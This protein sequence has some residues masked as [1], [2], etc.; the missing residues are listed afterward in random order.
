MSFSCCVVEGREWSDEFTDSSINPTGSE[1][2]PQPK[3]VGDQSVG[4]SVGQSVQLYFGPS[5]PSSILL[6]SSQDL[7]SVSLLLVDDLWL[8]FIFFPLR[9]FSRLFWLQPLT[10]LFFSPSLEIN[11]LLQVFVFLFFSFL[12]FPLSFL[13][14][15]NTTSSHSSR[16]DF[17]GV[18]AVQ[19]PL[20]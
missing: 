19:P 14:L 10:R 4:Q 12:F 7:L 20:N 11:V 3:Q 8:N 2:L 16:P 6:H 9:T 13:F 1:H 15:W 17:S 18:N 5:P